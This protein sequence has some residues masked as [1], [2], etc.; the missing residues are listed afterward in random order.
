MQQVTISGS[1]LR[2]K[3]V[4]LFTLFLFDILKI[5]CKVPYYVIYRGRNNTVFPRAEQGDLIPDF[6]KIETRSGRVYNRVKV[7]TGHISYIE[8]ASWIVDRN[9]PFL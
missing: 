6:I 4:N 8:K 9:N 1:I 3:I 2:H 5:V 7:T